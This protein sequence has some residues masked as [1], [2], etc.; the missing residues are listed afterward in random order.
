M[1]N[2]WLLHLQ[3]STALG[4]NNDKTTSYQLETWGKK[5]FGEVFGWWKSGINGHRETCAG[6]I[7]GAGI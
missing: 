7:A 4:T 5:A 6:S 1:Q 3:P 2:N